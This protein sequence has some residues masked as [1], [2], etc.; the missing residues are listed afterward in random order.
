M[1]RVVRFVLL[2][3]LIFFAQG[4]QACAKKDGTNWFRDRGEDYRNAVIYPVLTIP[5][6]FNAES[7]SDRYQVD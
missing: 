4:L 2:G 7:P 6:D 1:F 3:L 5:K